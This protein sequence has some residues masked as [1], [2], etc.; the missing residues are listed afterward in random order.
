MTVSKMKTSAVS[1]VTMP[2]CTVELLPENEVIN[3][4]IVAVEA[5]SM[6]ENLDNNWFGQFI[7]H[8][9]AAVVKAGKSVS[10]YDEAAKVVGGTI[11]HF[12]KAVMIEMDARAVEIDK[13]KTGEDLIDAKNKLSTNRGRIDNSIKSA[14]SVITSA[15]KLGETVLKVTTDGGHVLFRKDGTARGKTEL[16]NLIKRAKAFDAPDQTDLEKAMTAGATLARR[17][18]PLNAADR[19]LVIDTMR[20][21]LTELDEEA[22]ETEEM[23][24]KD[25]VAAA[26]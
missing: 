14:K 4:L 20:S 23:E 7:A 13:T 1:P 25:P 10:S 16:Q 22:A 2:K 19:K 11:D 3:N 5:G 18:V 21:K 8:S 26:A 12:K 17:L 24:D 15:L 6:V 9:R